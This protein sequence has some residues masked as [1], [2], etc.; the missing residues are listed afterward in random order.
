MIQRLLHEPGEGNRPIPSYLGP[1]KLDEIVIPV[2][3]LITTSTPIALLGKRATS[4]FISSFRISIR[5]TMVEP[6]AFAQ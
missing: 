4:T 5:R 6:A 2:V 1:D 3:Q